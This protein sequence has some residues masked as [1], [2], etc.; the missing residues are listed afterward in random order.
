MFKFLALI[1]VLS[2]AFAPA[3][4]LIAKPVPYF[5]QSTINHFRAPLWQKGPGHR[6]LDIVVT[7]E[8]QVVAPFDSS[9]HFVGRVV[10]RKVITLVSPSGL[11]A[12]FEPVCSSL[13][14]GQSIQQGEPVGSYCEPDETYEKHCVSCIHFSIRNKHG[15]LNPELFYGTLKVPGLL[16]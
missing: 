9:V 8:T 12:S 6:G 5:D 2:S 13:A 7:E 11:K 3:P 10:D 14:L 4:E 1:S 16:S 15:Y